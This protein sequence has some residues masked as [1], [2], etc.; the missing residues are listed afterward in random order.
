[1]MK[2]VEPKPAPAQDF[3]FWLSNQMTVGLALGILAL[4]IGALLALL[5]RVRLQRRHIQ[6]LQQM[7]AEGSIPQAMTETA[8]RH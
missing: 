6:R 4:S 7:L 2:K 3:N 1:V 5:T 8:G